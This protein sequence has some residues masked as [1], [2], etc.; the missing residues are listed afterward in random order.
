MATFRNAAPRPGPAEAPALV[1][2]TPAGTKCTRRLAACLRAAALTVPAIAAAQETISFPSRSSDL[3]GD[4]YWAVSEFGEGCCTLDLN[5][6]RWDGSGWERGSGSAANA[7]NYDWNVPL[8][9]PASGVIASCWRNFPDNPVPGNDNRHADYPSKIFTG[10]N[11]VVIVTDQGNAISL[12]HY[13]QGTIRPEL[14]PS[15]AGSTI[16]PSTMDKEGDWRVAA[17]IDAPNRPR[18][19]EGD[20]IGRA[21]SSGNSSGPHL[22]I[23][24]YDIAG[25]DG[26]GRET[27]AASSPLKFR[28]GWGHAFSENQQ[29]TSGGWYR[30]RGG[31]VDAPDF[32]M[33]HPSPY[34]RRASASA[35]AIRDVDTV[36]I[37]DQRA[38]TAVVDADGNLKLISWDLAGVDTIT[39]RGDIEAGAVKDAAIALASDHVLVAV[40]Q[41]DDVLKLIAYR[42]LPSG[43]F[44]RVADVSAGKISALAMTEAGNRRALTAVR[45]AGGNLKVIVWDIRLAGNGAA[46]IVRLGEASAGAISAL[47]MSRA[48]NFNGVYTAVRDSA[49]NLKV[50]PW[51]LS[52]DGRT[53]T[54]GAQGAAGTVGTAI[55]VA[56]LAQ[57]VAAAV[58]DE[59]GDLRLISWSANSAGDIGE[60]R[61]TA[62]AGGISEVSI[63]G[64]PRAGSNLTTV[65]RDAQGDLLLVG[66]AIDGD[67]RNIRRLGSTKAG[68][69]TRIAVDG[70]SRSYPG[71]DPR[72]M[73]LTALAD[74]GG[75]LKLVTWDTNLDNP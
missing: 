37:S 74:G 53:L 5:V 15:N 32:R 64:T 25:T 40:R 72:D 6:W 68:A 20:Y 31:N 2:T 16:Y 12:N 21:G 60:R 43:G 44:T 54:R 69:A 1:A 50:I 45:D 65:V 22:H 61:D 41:S 75:N 67:G 47:A 58:R 66:W 10:G 18:I 51:K 14:C 42:V 38:V 63:L 57:G 28:H 48:R 17:Y 19:R 30:L 39:R 62:V 27:L 49:N 34:L 11:H 35:G 33:L 23:A 29:H 8:Y 59:Q 7:Q 73:I 4:S 55:A 9:A 70:I 52:F 36:F 56:P 3:A 46:S 71:L 13:R 24:M 26:K